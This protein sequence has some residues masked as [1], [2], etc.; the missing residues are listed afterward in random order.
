MKRLLLF[1]L[2]I[3]IFGNIAAASLKFKVKTP[4]GHT[5]KYEVINPE[6]KIVAV[7]EAS[8]KKK[9]DLVIPDVVSYEGNE[10]VVEAIAKRAFQNSKVRNVILPNTIKHIGYLAFGRSIKLESIIL[11]E[12][13]EVIDDWAF[14]MT[15][16]L[17]RIS[18]PSTVQYVGLCAFSDLVNLSYTL[19]NCN[20]ENLTPI[21]TTDNCEYCGLTVGSVMSYYM[22][23][24]EKMY[25]A[26]YYNSVSQ[27]I[28][29]AEELDSRRAK[30]KR[31]QT[32]GAVFSGGLS[33]LGEYMKSTGQAPTAVGGMNVTSY[34]SDYLTSPAY[35]AAI[36]AQLN[37]QMA[38]IR[39]SG[40]QMTQQVIENGKKYL[41]R[42]VKL[43]G[44]LMAWSNAYKSQTG[45]EPEQWEKDNWVR[46]N[47][48][49]LYQE[50]MMAR[51]T[52][53]ERTQGT[54]SSMATDSHEYDN[55]GHERIK[56]ESVE[57]LKENLPSEKE[58]KQCYGTGKCSNCVDGWVKRLGSED[59][60]CPVCFNHDGKCRWCLGNGTR[61]Q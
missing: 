27:Y 47:H 24:P 14:F 52:D 13:L 60:P 15:E 44:E 21:V 61:I 23:H 19:K 48:P 46:Q 36:Q 55:S 29:T 50:Y 25:E 45:Q 22:K 4:E 38:Q 56:R 9:I 51:V 7:E 37:Q 3:G 16:R 43:S 58:C 42:M 10:Y 34:S 41:E 30:E 32:L 18:I 49:E 53:F 26:R 8:V 35:L 28:P 12:G 31:W 39:A 11:P 2:A 57:K 20:I 54:S 6:E 33:F 1:V 5:I 40:Q 59:G 17:K